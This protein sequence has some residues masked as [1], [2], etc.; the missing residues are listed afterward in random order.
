MSGA[1]PA[2][3][4]LLFVCTGNICR[5]PMAEGLFRR[6]LRERRLPDVVQVRSA[7]FI[8]VPGNPATHLAALVAKE[9]GV[10][11]S[12]HRAQPLTSS[13]IREADL[14]L[15]ME[16]G[17]RWELLHHHQE[18]ASKVFLLRH[19]ARSGNHHRA[20]ADPYG[21]DLETYRSCFEEIRE[22]V[23]SL[24]EWLSMLGRIAPAQEPDPAGKA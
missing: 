6:L 12:Q 1:V 3:R 13:L 19:F 4:N 24:W 21:L 15:V 17:H 23:E 10:D 11:L 14:I 20:I 8:A 2:I 22:C 5:S 9:Y 16:P 18:I 7:G